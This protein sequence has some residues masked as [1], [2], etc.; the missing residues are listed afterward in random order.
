MHLL[1]HG[2][3][4][5]VEFCLQRMGL[6]VIAAVDNGGIGLA[7]PIADV[8]GLFQQHGLCLE[9][10]EKPRHGTAHDTAADNDYIIHSTYLDIRI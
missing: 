10:G 8:V 5:Y 7:L 9:P 3:A 2:V 4:L 6:A 1:E